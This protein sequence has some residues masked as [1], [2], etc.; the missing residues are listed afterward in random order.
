M[1]NICVTGFFA[2]GSSACFDYLSEFDNTFSIK[3]RDDYEHSL[4]YIGDGLFELY[5]R[6]YS[7][8]S[9]YLSRSHALNNFIDLFYEQYNNDY[10]WFGSYKK[11]LGSDFK[12]ACELFIDSISAKQG[13]AVD[14]ADYHGVYY[15][16]LK[17][18][19]QIGAHFVYGYKITKL[20]RQYKKQ[21][22]PFRYI[23]VNE[24]EFVEHT[25]EFLASYA[26][27]C[28]KE[29]KEVTLFDHLV[30]A[31]QIYGVSKLLPDN[32]KIILIDR[33]PVDMYLISKHIWGSKKNGYCAPVPENVDDFCFNYLFQRRNIGKIKELKNVLYLSF[34]DLVLNYDKAIIKIN[35]FCKLSERNHILVKSF[36][37]PEISKNNINLESLYPD[38]NENIKVIRN[39][40]PSDSYKIKFESIS[41]LRTDAKKVF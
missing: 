8:S 6:L 3:G 11:I 16:P 29:N 32:Y 20:G 14:L 19:L 7:D 33:N 35:E 38:E 2:S 41:R 10:G 5:D 34:E 4:F 31:E 25:K 9:N 22:R 23:T 24:E 30:S 15:S 27:L 12:N 36:F 37:N 18:V 1:N 17:A 28:N 39:K 13:V 26:K 21:S 40:I